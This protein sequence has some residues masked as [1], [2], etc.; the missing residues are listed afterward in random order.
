MICL[1]FAEKN[2]HADPITFRRD[3]GLRS[4]SV[5]ITGE[6]PQEFLCSGSCDFHTVSRSRMPPSIV[7]GTALT[8]LT[9]LQRKRVLAGNEPLQ[10]DLTLALDLVD[11]AILVLHEDGR[12]IH[13]NHAA[14][15]LAQPVSGGAMSSL[16]M[17]PPA[18]PWVACRKILRAYQT[19]PG[20]LERETR[21]PGTGKCWSLRISALPYLGV[22]PRRLVLV[23]RD[24]T[25]PVRTRERLREREV[26]AA[27]GALLAGAAHQ[28]K[29][30][31]FGLSATLDAFEER[32]QKDGAENEYFEN[33]RLGI[34]RMQT[35][36]RDLLDYGNPTACELSP[37][38]MTAMVRRSVNGCRSLA[39]RMGVSFVLELDE[40]AEV[41][42]HPA[43]VVRALEN[44]V[45]NAIQHSPRAGTVT[46]RLSHAEVDR[47]KL[48]RC[49]VLD[50][51]PG[52]PPE[53]IERLF[54]PFFSLRPGGTGLGLT[55]AKKIVEDLGGTIFLSNVSAGGARARLCLPL[56]GDFVAESQ[57]LLSEC[58]RG[59]K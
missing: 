3:F 20:L 4:E 28:A 39:T 29:N 5:Q 12:I 7:T 24:I 17:L 45:E 30:A 10:T 46:L 11:D 31:I 58:N 55:I 34:A 40:D 33:L 53:V 1:L 56:A 38:S 21:D 13:S 27:T 48:L 52:F 2:H 42:G 49:D 37:L 18:E 43:R 15:V 50:Q 19:H 26:M 51:G 59:P 36:M 35:L 44:L 6:R 47:R 57:C 32:I 41:M 25:D 23:V 9:Q 54:A 16:H 8:G 22:L 14:T